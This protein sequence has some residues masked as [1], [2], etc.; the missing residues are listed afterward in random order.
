MH[1]KFEFDRVSY[2]MV[3]CLMALIGRGWGIESP[4]GAQQDH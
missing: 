1:A 3:N 2:S 4:G